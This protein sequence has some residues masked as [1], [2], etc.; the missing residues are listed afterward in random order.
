M[1][2]GPDVGLQFLADVPLGRMLQ[3]IIAF[4][5][6]GVA[7]GRRSVLAEGGRSHSNPPGVLMRPTQTSVSNTMAMD[8]RTRVGIV[9]DRLQLGVRALCRPGRNQWRLS[10]AI[11]R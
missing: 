3:N 11:N 9:V 2:G 6:Y 8:L 10:T 7:D 1:T 4:S 5:G